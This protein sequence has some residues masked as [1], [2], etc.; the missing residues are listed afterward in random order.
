MRTPL[1]AAAA[2]LSATVSTQAL[3]DT[4]VR[5]ANG[6]QVGQDGK[7]E[8]FTGILI[9]N[10]GK[11]KRL[12]HGEMLKLGGDTK[13]IDARGRTLLPGLI[14]AHGH[15]MGLGFGA[16]QLDLVGTP[17]LADLQARLKAY[18][19]SNPGR[20]WIIGRGWNQENWA[21]KRFPT[22]ADLDAVVAD[23]PVWLERVDG[24]AAVANSAALMSP[25]APTGIVTGGSPGS[26]RIIIEYAKRTD[27]SF[28]PMK[29]GGS[30]STKDSSTTGR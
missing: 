20:G 2:L 11:V 3:A 7:L 9:G 24:H 4:L 22:S 8:R 16:L 28:S 14:D 1:L 19:A 27:E 6:I 15:V 12:L 17:S 23:R 18:A 10:D 5:N 21:G 13:V 30:I 26:A 25:S 29:T